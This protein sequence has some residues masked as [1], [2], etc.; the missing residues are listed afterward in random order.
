MFVPL[1]EITDLRHFG[2]CDLI[3]KDTADADA[4]LVNVQHDMRSLLPIFVEKLFQYEH[5]K[6]HRRIII[7][8]KQYAI[9]RRLLCFRPCLR[10]QTGAG[11]SAIFIIIAILTAICSELQSI[12]EDQF[13]FACLQDRQFYRSWKPVFQGD[14]FQALKS[15]LV[16]SPEAR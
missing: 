8:Q 2:L 11:A 10:C 14:V 16:K 15:R 1:G 12:R 3:R 5:N 4:L 13:G 9:E 6:F 7:I